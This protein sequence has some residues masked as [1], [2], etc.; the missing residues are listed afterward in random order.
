MTIQP[1][2]PRFALPIALLLIGLAFANALGGGFVHDDHR[3]IT[4]N[5]LIQHPRSFARALARDVWA[6]KAEDDRPISNYWRPVFVAWLIFNYQLFGTSPVGW[7]VTNLLL[8]A[9]VTLLAYGVA[10]RLRAPPAAAAVVAWL[11]AAHPAHVE[12]VTWV[13]GSPDLLVG[14]GLFGALR[15]WLANR[16]RPTGTGLFAAAACFT[17]AMFSKES[18]AAFPLLIF[19]CEWTLDGNAVARRAVR[20]RRA[21]A[22][23]APH[24]VVVGMYFGLRFLLIGDLLG[25]PHPQAPPWSAVAANVPKLLVFYMRQ[26]LLPFWMSPLHA[27]RDAPSALGPVWK[28]A[29]PIVLVVAVFAAARCW[30]RGPVHRFGLLAFVLLL[31][32]ALNIRA[33]PPEERVHDRYLYLP[34]WG[35]LLV[36]V[37]RIVEWLE[38]FARRDGKVSSS[39]PRDKAE[40]GMVVSGGAAVLAGLLA[41]LGLAAL[42]A[43]YNRAWTDDRTLWAWAAAADPRSAEAQF[44]AAI[45]AHRD[46]RLKSALTHL[47]ETLRIEA[48]HIDAIILRARMAA[49]RGDTASAEQDLRRIVGLVPNHESAYDRLG[50]LLVDQGRFAEARAVFKQARR[51]VPGRRVK[52]GYNLAVTAFLA[53]DLTAAAAALE[54]IRPDVEA[55]PQGG[56]LDSLARLGEVYERLGRPSEA[57]DVY[58]RLMVLTESAESPKSLRLRAEAVDALERLEQSARQ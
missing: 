30:R 22:A 38:A 32:P 40:P 12:S 55:N 57:R 10:R 49:D 9:A 18:A 37:T 8:H 46:G 39:S 23:A 6:F 42:T 26:V 51:D 33:F 4:D 56:F 14:V 43:L 28:W 58:R 5:Y 41:A 48:G 25:R 35:L 34:L 52:Y 17:V 47:N 54:S 27:L 2:S 16:E 36:V 45:G 15:I 53:G 7:H 21:L 13:S 24:L 29:P 11:F 44:R 19:A 50:A 1:S 31:A 20:L 3:Q